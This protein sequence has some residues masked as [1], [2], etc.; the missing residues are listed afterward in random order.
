[1][2]FVLL[3]HT[4]LESNS[5]GNLLANPTSL[6]RNSFAEPGSGISTQVGMTAPLSARTQTSKYQFKA[7][8]TCLDQCS[9]P[10]IANY[11]R[12]AQ[13]NVPVKKSRRRRDSKV[14]VFLCF[15]LDQ[16]RRILVINFIDF[17]TANIS[18]L[19]IR[20]TPSS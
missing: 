8:L 11:V 18:F 2:T 14:F 19:C 1:M 6:F 15:K 4:K 20:V 10:C 16:D 13:W 9:V 7:L 3:L 5:G 17:L 12:V